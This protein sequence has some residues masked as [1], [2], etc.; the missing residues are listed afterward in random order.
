VTCN[1]NLNYQWK[2]QLI[3]QNLVVIANT[4][5]IVPKSYMWVYIV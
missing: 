5:I 4:F 1:L 3:E 2:I